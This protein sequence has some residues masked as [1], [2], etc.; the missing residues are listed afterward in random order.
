M[1]G[2]TET[3]LRSTHHLIFM[4]VRTLQARWREHVPNRIKSVLAHLEELLE[5]QHQKSIPPAMPAPSSLNGRC[6]NWES[7]R[8]CCAENPKNRYHQCPKSCPTN[9]CPYIHGGLRGS[10]S[11]RNHGTTRT[12]SITMEDNNHHIS[13]ITYHISYIIYYHHHHHH[14]HHQSTT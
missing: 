12:V 7:N 9:H 10:S 6:I 5:Q 3:R 11:A 2:S 13:Y 4:M 8:G 14:H 1:L